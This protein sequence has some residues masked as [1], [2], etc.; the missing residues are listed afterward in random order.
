MPH[1]SELNVPW[2]STYLILSAPTES[3]KCPTERIEHAAGLN[4]LDFKCPNRVN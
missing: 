3:I 1:W 2:G 4:I